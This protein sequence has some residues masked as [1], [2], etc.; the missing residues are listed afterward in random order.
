MQANLSH[1]A[2]ARFGLP[3]VETEMIKKFYIKSL[4][5]MNVKG[6]LKKVL[7][8]LKL[9]ILSYSIFNTF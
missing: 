8:P 9:F 1:V 5:D 6:E 3:C 7:N 4:T 2:K